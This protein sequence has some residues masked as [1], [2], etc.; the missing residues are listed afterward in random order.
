MGEVEAST[1]LCLSLDSSHQ[2]PLVWGPHILYSLGGHNALSLSL[3]SPCLLTSFG[4]L[5]TLSP[6][7]GSLDQSLSPSL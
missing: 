3:R 4:A 7:S 5:C 1:L 2:F 6:I